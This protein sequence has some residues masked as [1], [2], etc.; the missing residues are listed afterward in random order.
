MN[1]LKKGSYLWKLYVLSKFHFEEKNEEFDYRELY[2]WCSVFN[3]VEFENG[4][5]VEKTGT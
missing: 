5:G 4:F 1:F 2:R 3:L